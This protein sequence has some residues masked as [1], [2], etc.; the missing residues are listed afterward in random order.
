VG[1]LFV[2][3]ALARLGLLSTLYFPAPTTI[4]GSLVSL[5][6]TGELASHGGTTLYRLGIGLLTGGLSGFLVGVVM[7]RSDPFRRLI[8]PVVGALYPIPKIAIL[9]LVMVFLGIGET[10]KLFVIALAAFFP[11]LI[12]TMGGVR[13]IPRIYFEVAQNYGTGR[14]DLLR[15][16]ILPASLPAILSGARIALNSV[17]HVTIAVEIVSAVRGLGALVWLSW[18]VLRVEQLY[19]TL[20]LIAFLGV[21]S[22]A[23]L[24]RVAGRLVPWRP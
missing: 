24:D 22:T 15:R 14:W 7:G 21:A 6:R 12:S 3:E 17:I 23:A 8:D 13:Q 4:A 10:S 1:L 2:W 16:V 9:P 5:A 20:A 19:A 11:M 18:E